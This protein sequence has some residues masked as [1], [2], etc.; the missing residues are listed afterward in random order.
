MIGRNRSRWQAFLVIAACLAVPLLAFALLLGAAEMA[1]EGSRS[2]GGKEFPHDEKRSKRNP[3]S[4][5]VN[6]W[7]DVLRTFY[8]DSGTPQ[9]ASQDAGP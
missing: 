8:L 3:V 2:G 1:T 6:S 9:P 5:K 7:V 4:I